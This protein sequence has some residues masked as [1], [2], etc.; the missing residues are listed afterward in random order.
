MENYTQ[1]KKLVLSA[2]KEIVQYVLVNKAIKVSEK[3]S[4]SND[5]VKRRIEDM[6]NVENKLFLYLKDYNFFAFHIDES[7]NIANTTQLLAFI[8]LDHNEAIIE[9]FLFCKPLQTYTKFKIILK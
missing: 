2:A 6:L 8:R 5:T 3:V 4:L 7:S 9:K 1:S